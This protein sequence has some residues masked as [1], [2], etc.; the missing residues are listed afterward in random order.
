MIARIT[1]CRDCGYHAITWDMLNCSKCGGKLEILATT[2]I[3]ELRSQ[4]QDSTK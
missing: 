2:E 4:S 3:K 1:T